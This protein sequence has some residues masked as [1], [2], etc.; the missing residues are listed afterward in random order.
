[1]QRNV[2]QRLPVFRPILQIFELRIGVW[3]VVVWRFVISCD[4]VGR[5]SDGRGLPPMWVR[6]MHVLLG[7]T[8][9]YGR[10]IW[11]YA[12]VKTIYTSCALKGIEDMPSA[13]ANWSRT[14]PQSCT[15]IAYARPISTPW[16]SP[17]Q[18]RITT[19]TIGIFCNHDNDKVMAIHQEYFRQSVRLY[20]A[21]HLP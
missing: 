4:E 10:F 21:C 17:L 13:L 7:V 16:N 6:D 15:P 1:M 11:R 2:L 5:N 18:I 9:F 8:N 14:H 19:R 20:I 3:E 12:V